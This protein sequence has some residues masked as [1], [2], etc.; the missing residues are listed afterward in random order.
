MGESDTQLKQERLPFPG[1]NIRTA[2][3]GSRPKEK[4]QSGYTS[5]QYDWM[6]RREKDLK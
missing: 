1:R 5:Q 3:G 2:F 4:G 6:R